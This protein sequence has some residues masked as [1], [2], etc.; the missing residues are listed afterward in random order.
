MI[1][2]ML[3]VQLLLLLLLLLLLAAAVAVDAAASVSD[4]VVVAAAALGSDSHSEFSS[5][6][7]EEMPRNKLFSKNNNN[8]P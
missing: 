5:V 4:P 7:G 2:F 6:A 1:V 8:I 3:S